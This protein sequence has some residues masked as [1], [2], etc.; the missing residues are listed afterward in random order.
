[1]VRSFKNF[2]KNDWAEKFKFEWN[3]PDIVQI[4]VW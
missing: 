1:M 3:L 2:L 4:K